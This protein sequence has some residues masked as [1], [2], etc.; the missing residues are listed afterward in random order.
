MAIER[1]V[2]FPFRVQGLDGVRNAFRTV[3]QEGT[4]SFAEV[5]KGANGAAREMTAYTAQLKRAAAQAKVDF[6]GNQLL[7]KGSTAQVA[8]NRKQFILARIEAEK[9][10]IAKGFTDFGGDL[11]PVDAAAAGLTT[12]LGAAS[13]AATGLGAVLVAAGALAVKSA[14]AFSEHE[15]ALDQFNATLAITGNLSQAS[16]DDIQSAADQVQRVTLQNEKSALAAAATLAKVPGITKEALTAALDASAR[17][18]DALGKDVT[19]T[20]QQAGEVLTAIADRDMKG[21]VDAL[22]DTNPELANLVIRL[23]EA[24]KTADAQ[25]AYIDGLGKAAGDGPDGL[26]AA[27]DKLSDSWTRF[28]QTLGRTSTAPIQSFFNTLSGWLDDLN[29]DIEKTGSLWK[30]LAALRSGLPIGGSAQ[31]DRTPRS[32][33][34]S[35]VGLALNAFDS[36]SA[37]A[38]RA[39]F[40]TYQTQYGSTGN[41]RKSGGGGSGKSAAQREAEQRAREAEQARQTADKVA[42]SN[43]DVIDSYARRAQEAQARLGLEGAALAAVERQQSIDTVVRQLSVEWVDKEVEARRLAA[44]GQ[45]D[46]AA[47]RADATRA[48]ED[49]QAALRANAAAAY[50]ADKAQEQFNERQRVAAQIYEETRTPLER[51]REEVEAAA[52][53]L[54]AGDIDAD[55]FNRRMEQVAEDMATLAERG[56][57]AWRGFGD[58][59]SRTFTDIIR[60]GGS[61][62]EILQQLIAPIADRLW[63]QNIELPIADAIDGLT[64]LNRERNVADARAQLPFAAAGVSSGLFGSSAVDAAPQIADLGQASLSAAEAIRLMGGAARGGTAD[65][66]A[67]TDGIVTLAMESDRTA[68]AMTQLVPQLAQFGGGLE[69]IIARF[70]GIGGGGGGGL[71]GTVLSLGSAAFGGGGL[72]SLAA[73]AVPAGFNF[74]SAF[75]AGPGFAGGGSPPIG[76]PFWTGENG[77]E[78]MLLLPGGGAHVMSEPQSRRFAS[79][80]GGATIVNQTISIPARADPRRTLNG[81]ARA[82]TGALGRANRRG[83]AVGP[84][85]NADR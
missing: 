15:K 68:Q 24:G 80:G 14:Q 52:D 13:V 49:Q 17:L 26:T 56:K 19:E 23:T 32:P 66:G 53:A 54:R 77:R 12:R 11:A 69:Q 42:Q 65:L 20:A 62:T 31:A 84:S 75:S 76:V 40:R 6:S 21:L 63:E 37:Q 64:G 83:L 67:G 50:D 38:Q 57:Q 45:F 27:T 18:A 3:S 36:A 25:R 10:V 39:Q 44:K 35:P 33:F 4:K 78:R 8:A 55:T 48:L 29:R 59:M 7:N 51:L 5:E 46:E 41:G 34:A 70:A 2:N 1:A 9:Q 79:E 22:K 30:T 71:L 81:I 73:T 74:S 43:Q 61:A 60:N 28:L 47:A 72:G 58:E 85:F 82:T 16:A